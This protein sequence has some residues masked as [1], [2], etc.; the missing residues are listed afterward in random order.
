MSVSF[1]TARAVGA[2]PRKKLA[3]RRSE[4]RAGTEEH[5][6][7]IVDPATSPAHGPTDLHAGQ[8]WPNFYTG[9]EAKSINGELAVVID[10]P[11]SKTKRD[12]EPYRL[13][14]P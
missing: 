13:G 5:R 9:D 8:N 2:S 12:D 1:T 10:N 14:C 4:D 3:Q 7:S 6:E 11:G